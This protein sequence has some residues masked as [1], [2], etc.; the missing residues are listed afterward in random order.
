MEQ[1]Q[2]QIPDRQTFFG[3]IGLCWYGHV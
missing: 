2:R 3:L 1:A